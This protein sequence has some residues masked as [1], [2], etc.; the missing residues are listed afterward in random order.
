MKQKL[1]DLI[2]KVQN[3]LFRKKTGGLLELVSTPANLSLIF[4][5]SQPMELRFSP[6]WFRK[7]FEGAYP[8][9]AKFLDNILAWD[10]VKAS[11][12]PTF[13]VSANI[14]SKGF[15]SALSSDTSIARD[16]MLQEIDKALKERAHTVDV[17]TV[18]V[19]GSHENGDF[20]LKFTFGNLAAVDKGTDD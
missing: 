10:I 20:V 8:D 11:T 18:R 12:L 19:D 16:V 5:A 9:G 1:K 17:Q 7:Q 6:E 13:A 4:D 3:K 2:R 15:V 14:A